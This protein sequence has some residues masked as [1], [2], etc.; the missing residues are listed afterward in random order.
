MSSFLKEIAKANTNEDGKKN[1]FGQ[2]AGTLAT[3]QESLA[4]PA[5]PHETTEFYN[6]YR[7]SPLEAFQ[8]AYQGHEVVA[9]DVLDED[10]NRVGVVC[11][12]IVADDSS[13]MSIHRTAL[14]SLMGRII[15]KQ[16]PDLKM[17]MG[18][19]VPLD[20]T[21]R[22]VIYG[23]STTAIIETIQYGFVG[24][25]ELISDYSKGGP[26]A[27]ITIEKSY[28]SVKMFGG[29]INFSLQEVARAG[30]GN[31]NLDVGKMMALKKAYMR[32]LNVVGYFGDARGGLQGLLTMTGT[33]TY[34]S[35]QTVDYGINADL[36]SA[37]LAD[38]ANKIPEV[39]NG[40]EQPAK[41]V[42]PQKLLFIASNTRRSGVNETIF[43][44]FMKREALLGRITDWIVDEH[45][46]DA[47]GGRPLV[48]ILPNDIE[49]VCLKVT[50]EFAVLDAQVQ[51]FGYTIH[52]FGATAGI[53]SEAPASILKAYNLL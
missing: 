43:E 25:M 36:L 32:Y 53:L 24:C 23:V 41:L 15:E 11:E 9:D 29:Q 20:T 34:V 8:R 51:N 37:I 26:S 21:Q 2:V 4:L 22:G 6:L 3:I 40:I 31:I 19:I 35:P 18:Q 1:V 10:G 17:A 16:Y 30:A 28:V 49:K 33:T 42:S 12:V 13:S 39:T 7:R 50:Q 48:L 38:M 45:L 27:D 5:V 52:G 47:D 46:K 44:E 14:A